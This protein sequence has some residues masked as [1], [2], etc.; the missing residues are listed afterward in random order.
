MFVITDDDMPDIVVST[1]DEM[2]AHLI[3]YP[4]CKSI[5]YILIDGLWISGRLY[6]IIE[7]NQIVFNEAGTWVCMVGYQTYRVPNKCN[8]CDTS[9]F[10]KGRVC[11]LCAENICEECGKFDRQCKCIYNDY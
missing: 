10:M 4:S 6:S 3:K 8:V 7:D 1:F 11:T 5:E 2:A 9:E